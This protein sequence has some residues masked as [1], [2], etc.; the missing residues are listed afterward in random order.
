MKPSDRLSLTKM[1]EAGL[2]ILRDAA[3][4]RMAS[5]LEPATL[6]REV[7]APTPHHPHRGLIDAAS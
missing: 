2:S 6:Q 7:V 5:G 3:E 4:L 1:H